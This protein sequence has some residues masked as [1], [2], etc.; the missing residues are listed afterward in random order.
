MIGARAYSRT[1]SSGMKN[2]SLMLEGGVALDATF[3][4][5]VD[6]AGTRSALE[7]AYVTAWNPNG[8]IKVNT[9][10]NTTSGVYLAVQ[11]NVIGDFRADATNGFAMVA[12][13][14]YPISFYTQNTAVLA[15]RFWNNGDFVV[16]YG[17]A[18]SYLGARLNI[19]GGLIG[20]DNLDVFSMTNYTKSSYFTMSG[21][22]DVTLSSGKLFIND[23]SIATVGT[24]NITSGTTI[25]GLSINNS[26][27][28][29]AGTGVQ[30]VASFQ[31][32]IN[33][34]GLQSGGATITGIHLNATETALNGMT[35]NLITLQVNSTNYFNV[36]RAGLVEATGWS[37]S[38]GGGSSG[39]F[40]AVTNGVFVMY[41]SGASGFTRLN[42][43]SQDATKPA[44]QVNG[45]G[46]E[47]RTADG[48]SL[49][50]LSAGVLIIGN[51]APAA[52]AVLQADSTTKGFLPPRMTTIQRNAISSPA[53]G[54]IVFDTDLDVLMVKS[55]T[56]WLAL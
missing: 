11:N 47:V 55:S 42:F 21:N 16:G 31:Y 25:T 40:L 26:I 53:T 46:L 7:L 36:T 24:S 43:G 52:S 33:N 19:K 45:T 39:R 29:A 8:F 28:N 35:H 49:T 20:A 34:S 22:G 3:R 41:N 5:V 13:G 50:S 17:G 9:P 44:L 23:G 51:T 12:Q 30:K 10:Y 4:P 37:F 48:G 14:S 1:S 56:A 15:G 32:T 38:G 6:K 2:G 54:L 27:T 18:E